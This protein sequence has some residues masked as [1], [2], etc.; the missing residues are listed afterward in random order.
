MTKAFRSRCCPP[1]P[2]DFYA[3]RG[4]ECKLYYCIREGLYT[5]RQGFSK[6]HELWI[7]LSKDL[8]NATLVE[9]GPVASVPAQWIE[10]SGALRGLA[11]AERDNFPGYDEAFDAMAE[12]IPLRRERSREYGLMNFGDWYGER[13]CNWGNLEY[14]LGHGL[15][16]Q[17][18]R[19]G[20]APL[21]WRAQEALRHQGDVDTR[22]YASDPRRVGQQWTHCMGHTAYYYPRDY[23][24]MKIY[25]SPGWSDNRG[26]VWAQGLLEH[27]L[28]GGDRRSWNTGIL[29]ADWAAGPQTTNFRF[30]NAREPG[31]MLKLVMSAYCATDDPYYLNSARRMVREVRKKSEA[32]GNRGFYYHKLSKGHCNCEEKHYG[33][34]GFMLGVLMTGLKMYYDATGEERTADDIVGI[35]RFICDTMWVEDRCAFRYTSCPMTNAGHGSVWIMLEG[36]AFAAAR[37]GDER[38]QDISRR[39]LAAGW[40]GFSSGGKSSGYMICSSAQGIHEFAKIPGPS[41]KDIVEATLRE[42]QNPARRGLPTLLNNPDFEE[43]I[44]G[45]PPRG[46]TIGL[47][48]NVKH[49]GRQSL[50]F[51]GELGRQNEYVN[52]CYDASGDPGEIVHLVPNETYR[53]TCWLR[54]DRLTPGTPAPSVRLAFRDAGGTRGS[55]ATNACDLTEMGT[56][57]KLSADVKIPE[58]NTRNYI[59]LNTNTR[60]KL[61][62]LL[63]LDD[64]SLVPAKLASKDT[65]TYIRLDPPAAARFPGVSLVQ[66]KSRLQPNFLE[67]SG[68]ASFGLSVPDAGDYFVWARANGD[69][70]IA[71][72]SV[73]SKTVGTVQT[74]EKGWAWVRVGSAALEPG[75][76]TLAIALSAT[77]G[78]LGRIVVTNDPSMAEPQPKK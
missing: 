54:V 68:T 12:S 48:T 21:F 47:D 64:V 70:P 58:W 4:D 20:S 67:G 23:R 7:D 37:S 39:A 38:L 53:L 16:T 31:W 24:N 56:W 49:R 42:L 3:G 46:G 75:E 36:L 30:G 22:H 18:A 10:D 73:S 71:T 6:T 15:L 32:S 62:A 65:Y 72:L 43:T 55:K 60:E 2:Q 33:E 66:G 57:Q 51:G 45:W 27:Y 74:K 78:Q 69:A 61:E 50:R 9:D 26:H 59:A 19:T 34:A 35:A 77:D 11:V 8:A 76:D 44:H 17:F 28:L 25:A 52:T 1:L 63:Y 41:L 5:F 40:R 13:G 14:D 29:I